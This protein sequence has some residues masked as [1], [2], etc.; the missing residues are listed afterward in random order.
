MMSPDVFQ[1][2]LLFLPV[3]V[4]QRMRHVSRWHRDLIDDQ[5]VSL[6]NATLCG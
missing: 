4:R 6:V 1:H 3:P 5:S 2:T